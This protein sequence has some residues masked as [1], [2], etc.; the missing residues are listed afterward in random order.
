MISLQ[1]TVLHD[2]TISE[3]LWTGGGHFCIR[4]FCNSCPLDYLSAVVRIPGKS[5]RW[6]LVLFLI[7][8]N[9]I[10]LLI[11]SSVCSCTLLSSNSKFPLAVF[12]NC[13]F[14][15]PSNFLEM[16]ALRMPSFFLLCYLKDNLEC[17][18]TV[19]WIF[20]KVSL[21]LLMMAR[22]ELLTLDFEATM[23]YFRVNIPRYKLFILRLFL[24]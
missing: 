10:S 19:S 15:L 13:N 1:N 7:L 21:A 6:F 18:F 2:W 23:K 20:C 4:I 9:G 17:V 8:D 12:Y 22:K 11:C 14:S 5:M 3:M 24:S 16:W